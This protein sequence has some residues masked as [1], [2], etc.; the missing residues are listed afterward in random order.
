MGRNQIILLLAAAT[1]LF[2]CEPETY[3]FVDEK[4][5]SFTA[6]GG[7]ATIDM[8]ANKNWSVSS[9]NSWC[10]VTPASGGGDV[11]GA[12]L[13]VTC[14]KNEGYDV[15]TATITISC[16]EMMKRLSVNQ[17]GGKGRKMAT[18]GLI[19]AFLLD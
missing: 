10:T 17:S 1:L 13:T 16:A 11:G 4:P 3:L 9:D 5:L 2:G 12:R 18:N 6:E 14:N 19:W 8:I 7:G 15:R